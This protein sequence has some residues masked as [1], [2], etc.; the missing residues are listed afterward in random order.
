MPEH[1][2]RRDLSQWLFHW[3]KAQVTPRTTAYEVLAQILS[4]RRLRADSGHI[5]GARKCVCF[6]E[7]TVFEVSTYFAP[8]PGGGPPR[9]EPYGIAVRKPWLFER[10]MAG[11]VS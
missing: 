7:T 11:R 1:T 6:T 4:E 9:Y 5:R 8:P 2:Q 10:G 3:T